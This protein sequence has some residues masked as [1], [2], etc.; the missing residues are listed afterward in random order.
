MDR[1]IPTCRR[2]APRA[3]RPAA[4]RVA[5]PALASLLFLSCVSPTSAAGQSTSA[6][7]LQSLTAWGAYLS[8]LH[9][10]RQKDSGRASA[11][12]ATVTPDAH[13]RL[14]LLI[15]ALRSHVLA[16]RIERAAAVAER[17]VALSQGPTMARLVLAVQAAKQQRFND[18]LHHLDR[19]R[20][21]NVSR[22]LLPLLRAWVALGRHK[23]PDLA[24]D[25]H[26]DL[27]GVSQ[28]RPFRTMHRAYLLDVANRPQRAAKVYE[29]LSQAP[30]IEALRLTETV[31][32]FLARSG[33]RAAALQAVDRY[34]AANPDSMTVK[35]LRAR[36][37][38]DAPVGPLVGSAAD[39][40]AEVLLNVA[41][42]L[43]QADR[44]GQAL[45]LAQLAVWMRP[46]DAASVFLLGTVLESDGRHRNAVAAFRKLETGTVYSW[47]ARKSAAASLVE[48]ERY[49]EASSLLDRMAAEKPQR[50]DALWLLG[51]VH[52]NRSSFGEA[53]TAYDRAVKRIPKIARRHW[54]LL[55]VRGI[56]LERSGQWAR[57]EADFLR[58]LKLN[59]G[60]PYVLNYLAYS[61]VDRGEKLE[62]ARTMLEEAVGKRPKDGYI[63]D[64][65]GWVEFRLGNFEEAVR[66]LERAAEL[67]PHDPIIN[68]HLGDA[69]WRAGRRH[70]ARF[71][72]KRALSF[73]PEEAD[74]KKIEQ[75]LREGMAPFEPILRQ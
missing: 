2:G 55:Y 65:V 64:S 70:E 58:A 66:H 57:A 75:R 21:D 69:Y 39:G 41:S 30:S 42:A 9:A 28:F 33:G 61:W 6:P 34:L 53:V 56:A 20:G 38:D 18:A 72:W 24:L 12:F 59:P 17:T 63:V 43:H 37:L 11:Y 49:E 47:E 51:N 19:I 40:V 35:S 27:E 15:Q 10:S 36:Y 3:A 14:V 31:S 44:P 4:A 68:Q 73:D 46:H 52:R 54:N 67:R 45:P 5:L 71:Q 48:L 1:T 26:R 29:E 13:D 74:R 50:Y 25:E 8:A 22:L 62:R 32:N 23:D 16:G 60:Q 7:P